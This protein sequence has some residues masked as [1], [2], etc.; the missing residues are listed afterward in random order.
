MTNPMRK[1][2]LLSAE[3]DGQ[4][5]IYDSTNCQTHCLNP[6]ALKVWELCD[7]RHSR[8]DMVRAL[9]LQS[10]DAEDLVDAA[11][12]RFATLEMLDACTLP[13]R[14]AIGKTVVKALAAGLVLSVLVPTRAVADSDSCESI[15]DPVTCTRANCEWSDGNCVT[16]GSGSPCESYEEDQCNADPSC[17]WI[18]ICITL[19]G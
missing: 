12:D 3:V 18:G 15:A 10:G 16:P 6:Q 9:N 2:G 11:L 7:G 17:L 14:R 4:T 8:D 1:A 5:L 13:S 19:E